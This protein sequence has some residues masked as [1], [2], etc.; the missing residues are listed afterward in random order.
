MVVLAVRLGAWG[1]DAK[2]G[3]W[4]L[5]VGSDEVTKKEECQRPAGDGS[6]DEQV[7]SET[8]DENVVVHGIS[9]GEGRS[10]RPRFNG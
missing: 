6:G 3:A 8:V 7:T 9:G 10:H 1:I 4:S 5:G 2:G